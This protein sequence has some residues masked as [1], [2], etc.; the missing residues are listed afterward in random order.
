MEIFDNS[1]VDQGTQEI[2]LIWAGLNN[3]AV[4]RPTDYIKSRMSKVRDQCFNQSGCDVVFTIALPDVK[5]KHHHN[6]GT[7]Y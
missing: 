3:G 6:P 7:D 2:P 5:T 1:N 4:G